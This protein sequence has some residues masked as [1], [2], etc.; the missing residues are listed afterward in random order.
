M[1]NRILAY[2]FESFLIQPALP[3]PPIVC[4]SYAHD[5]DAPRLVH[6]RFDKDEF[7]AV[8]LDALT[9]NTIMVAHN[10]CGFEAL[11][12]MAYSP[13]WLP[14]VYGKLRR[15]E[16]R[17]TMIRDKEIRIGK[18]LPCAS[19]ASLQDLVEHYDLP[20]KL[21]KTC[22]WRLRYGLLYGKPISEWPRE[23]VDYA[24]GDVCVREVYRAQEE[25]E[26]PRFLVAQAH[27]FRT[28]VMLA[29]A[30]GYGIATDPAQAKKL[31]DDT[32]AQLEKDKVVLLAE[33]LLR[34]NKDGLSKDTKA[35]KQRCI[36]AYAAMGRNPPTTKTGGVALNEEACELSGDPVLEA[37]SRYGQSETLLSKAR[38]MSKPVVSTG[39]NPLVATGR[40][41]CRA[42]KE[43][44]P[45]EAWT[46]F[47]IQAQNLP[48]GG[49]ARECLVARG[50][51]FTKETT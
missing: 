14:L 49:G 35:A 46:S 10:A 45:G 37:Y 22:W 36:D 44:K 4:M 2:D 40:T 43:P 13:S 17:C 9:S 18:G 21:D 38:R 27:S 7:E 23:A 5:N 3:A 1:S 29:Q 16:F 41:S 34:W 15:G 50:Y 24:L 42:G 31:Y 30:G 32:E 47:G 12:I 33:G 28:G 20:F 6:A 19:D 48:R 26:D 11:C 51:P 8:L 39:Y 25:R